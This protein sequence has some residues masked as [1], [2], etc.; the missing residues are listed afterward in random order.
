MILRDSEHLCMSVE[1]RE[2][3]CQLAVRCASW[4]VLKFCDCTA[5]CDGGEFGHLATLAQ[6][7]TNCNTCQLE[8]DEEA[9][10]VPD[11]TILNLLSAAAASWATT[12]ERVCRCDLH[13]G[14]S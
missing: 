2:C 13:G 11:R 4:G 12:H 9:C 8:F 14:T 1:S 6:G 7:F 5:G 3:R 10:L